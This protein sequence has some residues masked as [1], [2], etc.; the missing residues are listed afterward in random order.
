MRLGL[1]PL[2]R[3]TFDVPYAEEKLAGM[4]SEH[5]HHLPAARRDA[6]A[7]YIRGE[8]VCEIAAATGEN[9]KRIENLVYRGLQALRR[10]LTE[11]GLRP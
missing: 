10:S 9:A 5:L 6:V 8:R 4:L 3:P 11:A 1:L 7:R 2:G